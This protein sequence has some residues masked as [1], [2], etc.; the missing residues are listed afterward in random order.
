MGILGKLRGKRD[1]EDDDDLDEL[2]EESF[3][4]DEGSSL[5]LLG[6][7]RLKLKR[8]GD[9]AGD[10][11]DGDDDDRDDPLDEDDGG[12]SGIFGRLRRKFKRDNDDGDE[13]DDALGLASVGSAGGGDTPP[14]PVTAAPSPL[15]APVAGVD[16]EDQPAETEGGGQPPLASAAGGD[17]PSVPVAAVDG[18]NRPA[19]TQG[20]N[21]PPLASPEPTTDE[22][23]PTGVFALDDPEEGDAAPETTGVS[24][25]E[26]AQEQDT[27]ANGD[28][29]SG[30]GGDGESRLNLSDLFDTEEEIDEAFKDLVDSMEEVAASE[31]V[32]QLRDLMSSLD[33]GR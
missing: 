28:S 22:G 18:E 5:G 24:G 3:D 1:D 8:S 27:A 13:D 33:K 26:A 7:M 14:V 17:T 6:R 10:G 19:E 23:P 20:A 21:Q 15:D 2:D 11:D 12:S 25:G 4:D 9:G 31:L 30:S 32:T 29:K 16:G